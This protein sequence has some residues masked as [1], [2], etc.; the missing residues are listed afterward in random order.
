MRAGTIAALCVLV[1]TVLMVRGCAGESSR[2]L[3]KQENCING[4]D[5]DLDGLTDGDDLEDCPPNC[6][7]RDLD[8]YP[9][10]SCGGSDCD[11]SDPG[12]RPDIKEKCTD[13]VDNNCDGLTD[14]EDE[15]GCP[16]GCADA[17]GDQYPDEA[18]G[19][20]DCDDSD[21]QIRPDVTE[22]CT[23][24]VD[25]NCDG[26]TDGEDEAA[27]PPECVDADGDQYP[28]E[29][30]G[31]TDCDDADDQVYP[32]ASETCDGRDEDCDGIF[33][34]GAYLPDQYDAVEWIPAGW[35]GLAEGAVITWSGWIAIWDHETESVSGVGTL[36]EA[37]N[38]V[39]PQGSQPPASGIDSVIL[40]PAGMF[41]G[42]V[43]SVWVAA[44]TMVY[45]VDLSNP[46]WQSDTVANVLGFTS[47]V[48]AI[49]IFETGDVPNV[50]EDLLVVS[51][52]NQMWLYA[53]SS[54]V[55]GPYT[56]Q[57][58]LCPAGSTGN[59][60]PGVTAM[61]RLPGTPTAT[62]VVQHGGVSY[63]SS[64]HEDGNGNLYYQWTD[65]YLSSYSCVH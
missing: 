8:G 13:G 61:A 16:P 43:E 37:W 12:I 1:F 15:E 32:G 27:C 29:A 31:G 24:S 54:G 6:E 28:D 55:L 62:V 40:L 42:T 17:D 65:G 19:G 60:P 33:D 7:D 47:H 59:C 4:I 39:S 23:D 45:S 30:C 52:N 18:C 56:V 64:F 63:M 9:D 58:T 34:N 51:D 46:V 53:E 3:P 49:T 2:P 10:E 41:G 35:F 11:D 44:G 5:D 14:G 38:T 26:L 57:E 50:D 22:L 36:A 21:D 20:P 48:D 25:N